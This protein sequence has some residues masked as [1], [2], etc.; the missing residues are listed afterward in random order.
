MGQVLIN[1]INNAIKFTPPGGTIRV[2]ALPIDGGQGVRC[3]VVDTG[4][5]LAAADIPKLFQRFSQVGPQAVGTGLGLSISKALVE[6]HGGEIG[7]TSEMGRGSTF[8]FTLPGTP[9]DRT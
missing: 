3:E 5:G 6:A 9:A 2:R 8:W 7:V 1:L 4:Y